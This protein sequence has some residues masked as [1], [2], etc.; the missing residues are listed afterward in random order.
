MGTITTRN[1]G[2]CETLEA[3]SLQAVTKLAVSSLKRNKGRLAK[4]ENSDEGLKLFMQ[5]SC[6]FFEYVNEINNDLDEQ[7]RL[8]PDIEGLCLH[9]GIVR[10]TLSEYSRRN[11]EWRNAIA[12]VKQAISFAKKQLAFRGKIP[13][14]IAL[15]DLTNNHGYV[16]TSEFHLVAEQPTDASAPQIS[17]AEIGG[18]LEANEMPKLPE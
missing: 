17:T 12:S 7:K 4:Y 11:E 6:D 3:D 1:K 10:D 9:L 18:L 15:F 8:I 14:L 5:K 13:P 2:T 16:S